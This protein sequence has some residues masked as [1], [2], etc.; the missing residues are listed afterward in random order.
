MTSQSILTRESD[1]KQFKVA[2]LSHWSDI[3]AVDGSG[4]T[5][6]VKWYGGDSTGEFYVSDSKG[7]GYVQRKEG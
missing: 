6:S 1:G 4:E 2:F 3:V 5:D 7:H